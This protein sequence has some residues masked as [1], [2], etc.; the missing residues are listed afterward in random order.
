M[1]N[2][3]LMTIIV[4][5]VIVELRFSADVTEYKRIQF[6]SSLPSAFY[7]HG[8]YDNGFQYSGEKRDV[9]KEKDCGRTDKEGETLRADTEIKKEREKEREGIK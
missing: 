6:Y 3:R 4:V 5:V 8:A 7:S 1:S 9:T 2:D